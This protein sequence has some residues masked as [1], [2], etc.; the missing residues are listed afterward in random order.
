MTAVEG[1]EESNMGYDKQVN[2]AARP[3]QTS[4]SQ[5]VSAIHRPCHDWLIPAALKMHRQMI[6]VITCVP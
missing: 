6:C 2:D 3:A 5:A 1:V 4:V